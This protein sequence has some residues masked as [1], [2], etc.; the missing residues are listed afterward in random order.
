M[1]KH[2]INKIGIKHL[3]TY[4]FTNTS[5]FRLNQNEFVFNCSK[6]AKGLVIEIGSELVYGYDRHFKHVNFIRTNINFI[7]EDKLDVTSIEM[8]DNSVDNYLCI[9]VL[10]HV[11]EIKKAAQ[12]LTRTLKHDGHLFITVPFAYPIHDSVD[13][14]RLLP[15]SYKELFK[16]F[17][18]LELYHF[19]GKFSSCAEVFQRPR[20]K[21]AFRLLPAKLLGWLALIFSLFFER[22][23]GFPQGYG[24]ILRKNKC[25]DF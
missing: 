11:F 4:P 13:Y 9:S 6:F 8:S 7:G 16:D 2:L 25:A 19:G 12:E 17:E 1:T 15:D 18:I 20:G 21:I 14:Y 23:D 3:L 10:E 5:L 22:L 24:L